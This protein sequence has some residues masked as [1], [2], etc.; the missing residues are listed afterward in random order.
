MQCNTMHFDIAI[1]PKFRSIPL[2]MSKLSEGLA[3]GPQTMIVWGGSGTRAF[4]VTG[5]AL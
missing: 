4:R 2:A 1:L 3:E 5:S